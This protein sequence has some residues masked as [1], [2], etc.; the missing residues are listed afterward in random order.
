MKANGFSPFRFC[1]IGEVG[2]GCLLQPM[3]G[4]CMSITGRS[5]HAM[6]LSLFIGDNGPPCI[7]SGLDTPA[8]SLVL[9]TPLN[10]KLSKVDRS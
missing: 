10:F 5:G 2:T 9:I 7:Q 4:Q 3:S 1:S 8:K 6:V